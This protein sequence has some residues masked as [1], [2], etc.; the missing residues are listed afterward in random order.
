[1][2]G[3]IVEEEKQLDVSGTDC[4]QPP[5]LL[6]WVKILKFLKVKRMA[7]MEDIESIV[8]FQTRI[9]CVKPGLP[10]LS[11]IG[12]AN[13]VRLLLRAIKHGTRK[14]GRCSTCCKVFVGL[15]SQFSFARLIQSVIFKYPRQNHH[16]HYQHQQNANARE[17]SLTP[18]ICIRRFS[19]PQTDAEIPNICVLLSLKK[20]NISAWDIIGR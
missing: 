14:Q 8:F 20:R 11:Q 5:H 13:I 4:S 15:H 10:F 19:L 16:P 3:H 7:W 1:M 12:E 2:V 17:R 6:W 18:L 9:G